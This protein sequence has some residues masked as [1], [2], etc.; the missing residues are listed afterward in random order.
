MQIGIRFVLGYADRPK[1]PA[2]IV[3]FPDDAKLCG[4]GLSGLPGQLFRPPGVAVLRGER[5]NSLQSSGEK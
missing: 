5:R 3:R 1:R 2:G 4:G